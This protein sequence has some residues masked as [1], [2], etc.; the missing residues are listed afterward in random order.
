MIKG[1]Y[2]KLN[3]E[4]QTDKDIYNYFVQESKKRKLNK[5]DLLF[6]LIT[7]QKSQDLLTS[8]VNNAIQK[9]LKEVEK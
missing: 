7:T 2:F 4:K 1:L 9:Q 3:M 8:T 6:R 5:I